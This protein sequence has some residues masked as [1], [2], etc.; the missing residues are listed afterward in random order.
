MKKVIYFLLVSLSIGILST[1]CNKEDNNINDAAV[2][3]EVADEIAAA[4]GESNSGLSSEIVE[5]ADIADSYTET[6]KS[7][8]YDT[9]YS[10]DTSFI[11]TNSAGTLITYNY[12]Y[13]ME[14]GYVFMNGTL[15][16]IYYQSGV[17]GEF[18]A[19]RLSSS[20]ERNSNWVMTGLELSSSNYI[21][22]GETSRT[23]GSMSKIR[24]KSQISSKS[25][26]TVSNVKV[27]K[28]NL[29]ITEGTLSWNISGTV[30]EQSFNYSAT[31]VYKGNGTAEL[32]ING[33]KY[34]INLSS[35]EIE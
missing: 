19:P 27:N 12:S 7:D 9:I 26:I 33:V 13:N 23:A 11:R 29:Y 4:I 18:D 24:N 22:N 30:N 5:M 3:E 25:Q 35:G 10:V 16:N 8:A 28:S 34:T 17:D 6:L 20:N 31:V 1:S 2:T 15:N 21:I 32:T 14:Y